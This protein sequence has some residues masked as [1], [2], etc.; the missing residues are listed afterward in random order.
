M[1]FRG[2][3]VYTA[4]LSFFADTDTSCTKP[5]KQAAYQ[6]SINSSVAIAPP[7]APILATRPINSVST[8]TQTL[9]F[10]GNPGASSYEVRY[11]KGAVLNPDG[12]INGPSEQAYVNSATGQIE[13]IGLR[14]P[15]VYTVVARAKNLDYYSP[16]SAPVSR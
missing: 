14:E 10:A 11:A 16:W 8:N 5:T 2:N 9:G 4:V 13:L 3:G 1:I 15:G 6:F 7:A 12:S